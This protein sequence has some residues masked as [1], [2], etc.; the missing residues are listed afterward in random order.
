MPPKRSIT[1]S[2]GSTRS[3]RPSKRYRNAA[4]GAPSA[5]D[6][7]AA[8]PRLAQAQAL[9]ERAGGGASYL[10]VR[11]VRHGVRSLRETSLQVAARGLYE[12]VRIARD[13]P[14][15]SPS[16]GNSNI[17][18]DPERDS[19]RIEDARHLR[20]F[21]Q[22]LPVDVAN[23]LMRLVLDMT[24]STSFDD[25]SDPGVSVMSIAMLFFHPNTTRLSLSGMA[26][27]MLLVSRIPHCTGLT[28]LDLS[29]HVALRD[30]I[31]AKVVA[32]LP[33]LEIVN[34]KGCTKIGDQTLVALSMASEDRLRV[35]NLSL[36][37]VTI[38]GLTSLLAR[39][40]NLEV[41]K[42][43]NVQG[44]V[45]RDRAQFKSS[46]S[47]DTRDASQN[48]RN[49][50]KWITDATDA[51]LGWRHAPLS[52]LRT[53]KVRSTEFTDASIG[54]LLSLCAPTL[55]RLDV[56]YSN[57]K[58]LDFISSALHTL[59]EWKLTKLVASGLPLTPTT[60]QGFFDPL[61]ER[62]DEERRRFSTLKLGSLPAT[63]TKAPGLTDAVL[64]KLM[65]SLEKLDG[66]EKVSLFQNWGLG[67]LEQPL[68]RFVE[69][70]G[71]KCTVSTH[72]PST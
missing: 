14:A 41:L 52:R 35:V 34:L 9:A 49:V 22:N 26:A 68:S 37:A 71:R 59:P 48:E 1:T 2:G 51:A 50:S 32:Q 69:V 18:W 54:R 56:S 15:A 64:A 28:E 5:D 31:L 39:C 17:G 53:L 19:G 30:P 20:T 23:R 67:K 45:S 4:I 46:Y 8:S 10:A 16:K 40:K 66:L 55:E 25:P 57:L 70:I 36:T 58:T 43:A 47:T 11:P 72:S 21:I 7:A 6:A 27:P 33:T 12:S 62:P 60:L 65:P 44:L 61:A 13:Q 3:S 29:G 63:S 42:L 38:K 24:T